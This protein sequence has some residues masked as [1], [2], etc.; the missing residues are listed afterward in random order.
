MTGLERKG[1][2]RSAQTIME[3]LSRTGDKAGAIKWR[4]EFKNPMARATRLTKKM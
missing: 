4:K 2:K 1:E 3:T